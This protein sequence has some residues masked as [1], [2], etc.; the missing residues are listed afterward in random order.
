VP[1]T[2]RKAR[3]RPK[4]TI[5]ASGAAR[6]RVTQESIDQMAELRRQGLPFEEIG[7]RVG[8]SERTAR[9]YAGRVQPQL[10]LPGANPEPD[11]EDPRRMRDR[12]ARWCS[13]LLYNMPGEP[14][15]RDSVTFLAE[16][17]RLVQERLAGLDVLTLELLLRDIELRGRFIRE[18]VG[19]LWGDF[20]SHVRFDT[21]F[22]IATSVSAADWRPLRERTH[23]V[24]QDFDN[25]EP[26]DDQ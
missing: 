18:V 25:A 11:V 13:D 9:R 2:V 22:G 26:D 12:L 7:A 14:R 8:C 10:H 1:K 19:Y 24:A 23:D 4:G 21:G 15:P 20:S 3:H 6:R 17:A 5:G 16:A